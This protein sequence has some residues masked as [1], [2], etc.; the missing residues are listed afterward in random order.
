[1]VRI[2]ETNQ[3]CA[4]SIVPYRVE[5]ELVQSQGTLSDRLDKHSTVTLQ[6]GYLPWCTPACH[7]S[8]CAAIGAYSALESNG[9]GQKRAGVAVLWQFKGQ[10][11]GESVQHKNTI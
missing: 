6:V 10:E 4:G 9:G 3:C 11:K 8:A 7:N 2:E 1:M 5:V